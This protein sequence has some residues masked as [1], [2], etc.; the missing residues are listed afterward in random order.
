HAHPADL[1]VLATSQGEGR[2][3]WLGSSV[4]EPVTRQAGEMTLLIPGD[5]EGFISANDGSVNLK[6]ILIPIARTPRP[7]PALH[8]AAQ[9]VQKLNCPEGVFT[10]LHVGESNT[11]PA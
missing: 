2:V 1:I 8:V 6:S 5:A 4:A 10:V 11:M 3:R 9:F 7:E